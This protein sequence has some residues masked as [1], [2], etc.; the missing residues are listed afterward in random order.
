M[1]GKGGV[2][3]VKRFR[4]KVVVGLGEGVEEYLIVRY[5]WWEV[6]DGISSVG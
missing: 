4:I 6:F 3:R 5:D 1:R 2:G